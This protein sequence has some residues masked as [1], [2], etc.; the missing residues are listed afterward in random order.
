MSKQDPSAKPQDDTH[1]TQFTCTCGKGTY[2]RSLG[3]DIALKLGTFGYISALTR[4]HVGPFAIDDAIS[5]DYFKEISDK[6]PIDSVVLPL[7]SVLD[8]IPVLP[9]RENEASR[10]ANG[11]AISFIARPD[12]ERLKEIGI[13]PGEKHTALATFKGTPLAIIEV[14]GPEIKVLRGLNINS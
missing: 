1:V 12:M 5:L 14:D 9:L 8:D 7:E 10:I 2:I 4:T 13:Q 3:R 11:N 6:P